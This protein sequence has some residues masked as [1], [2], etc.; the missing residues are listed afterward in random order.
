[1]KHVK[2]TRL[3]TA[4]VTPMNRDGEID[5]DSLE[6]LVGKQEEAGNGVLLLGS[7]GEGLALSDEEKHSVVRFVSELGPDIPLMVGV[8]GFN[9]ESQRSWIAACNGLSIHAFLLVAPLYS[10]PGPAG[11]QAWFEALLEESDQPCMLYN[12]PSRTGVRIP[13]GVVANLATHSRMWSLKEASGSA[14]EYRA[15]REAAP[16]VELFSGDDA[17]L[18]IYTE[19]GCSG[20]V[21][22][23]ANVWPEETSRYVDLTLDGESESFRGLW[24]R[25]S[26]ALFFASNPIP[27]KTL[28]LEKGWISTATL[29]LPLLREDLTDMEPLLNADRDIRKW[30]QSL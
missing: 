24:E 4:L 5:Y 28:L 11:M 1:M 25:A 13:P 18:P 29:R 8:G 21:S 6:R 14:D 2:E 17:H 26:E 27:A 16:T 15:F 23:A 7:T 22:V 10:K 12:I 3:W 19:I 9:L 20:L 30:Y